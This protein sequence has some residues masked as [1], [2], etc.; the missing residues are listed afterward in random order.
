MRAISQARLFARV[1]CRTWNVS[2]GRLVESKAW[3]CHTKAAVPVFALSIK[4]ADIHEIGDTLSVPCHRTRACAITLFSLY[5]WRVTSM[6]LPTFEWIK[7]SSWFMTENLLMNLWS[8]SLCVFKKVFVH[9][10]N[11]SKSLIPWHQALFDDYN[12]ILFNSVLNN[13]L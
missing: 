11:F 6:E 7:T 3:V 12:V 13:K 8:W 5:P 1:S 4:Y 2:R 10:G 9:F